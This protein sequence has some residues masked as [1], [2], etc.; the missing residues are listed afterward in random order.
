M[1]MVDMETVDVGER[2]VVKMKGNRI[3]IHDF[4]PELRPMLEA[5]EDEGDGFLEMDELSKIFTSYQAMR[6]QEAERSLDITLL[7][8]EVQEVCKAFD[9]DGDGKI[10]L[11]E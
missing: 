7:P 10:Q 11:H 3:H 1:K 9:E 4:P 8:S 5:V 2:Q 6:A